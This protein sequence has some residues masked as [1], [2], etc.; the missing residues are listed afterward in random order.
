MQPSICTIGRITML[1]GARLALARSGG[2]GPAGLHLRLQQLRLLACRRPPVAIS[3]SSTAAHGRLTCA[4]AAGVA[5]DAGGGGGSPA[6]AQVEYE[7]VIGIETHVQL[8]T[9][10][11]AFCSCASEFGAEPNSHVCPVCLGHPVSTDGRQGRQGGGGR[12][13]AENSRKP[14]LHL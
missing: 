11:K 2:V 13:S 6:A 9:R 7:A 8:N 3:S 10:T 5:T 1:L 4:A 14:C 12:C